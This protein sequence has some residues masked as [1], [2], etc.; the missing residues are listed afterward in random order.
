MLTSVDCSHIE[1]LVVTHSVGPFD[2]KTLCQN[3]TLDGKNPVTGK[4]TKES[5]GCSFN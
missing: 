4:D 3:P 5:A 1:V 2:L